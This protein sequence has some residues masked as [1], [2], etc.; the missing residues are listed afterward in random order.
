[1]ASDD[2]WPEFTVG[3][4]SV[5]FAAD[6]LVN[7]EDDRD[8]KTVH[9]LGERDEFTS[10]FL[11]GVGGVDDSHSTALQPQTHDSS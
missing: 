5:A 6:L 1:M 9:L 10:I 4:I 8:R 7:V 3:A 2:V 11:A